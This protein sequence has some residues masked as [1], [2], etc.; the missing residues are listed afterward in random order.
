MQKLWSVEL[1]TGLMY[2]K[3]T[4]LRWL[5]RMLISELHI[6][7][8]KLTLYAEN[9]SFRRISASGDYVLQFNVTSHFLSVHYTEHVLVTLNFEMV[10]TEQEKAKIG[11]NCDIPLEPFKA[12]MKKNN[13]NEDFD[14][15]VYAELWTSRAGVTITMTSPAGTESVILPSRPCDICQ[16]GLDHWTF[17]SVHHWGE[18]PTGTWKVK[19]SLDDPSGENDAYLVV[20]GDQT[21]EIRGVDE[22]PESVQRIP[23]HCDAACVRGCASNGSKYC[24]SCK[25]YRD[26]V[27][28]EC[29]DSCNETIYNGYCLDYNPAIIDDKSS[30]STSDVVG[31][32]IG[33]IVGVCVLVL[34]GI[35]VCAI[36]KGKGKRKEYVNIDSETSAT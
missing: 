9:L 11:D 19:I 36:F 30:L 2:L 23:A 24:D 20:T 16:N 14:P 34:I 33:V 13:V 29:L 6:L 15:C 35:V 3:E 7:L 17:L 12:R 5:S 21:L 26:P 27:T 25:I 31:I 8:C 10:T 18:D 28:L 22:V 32:A 1:L 4:S